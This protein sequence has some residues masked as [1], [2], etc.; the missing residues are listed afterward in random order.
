M[1]R[2]KETRVGTGPWEK[3]WSLGEGLRVVISVSHKVLMGS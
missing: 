3:G 2:S 1:S